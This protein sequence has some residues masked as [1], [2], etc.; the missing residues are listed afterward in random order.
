[1]QRGPLHLFWSVRETEWRQIKLQ[2]D[3]ARV[4]ETVPKMKLA[5]AARE[6]LTCR[7]HIFRDGNVLRRVQLTTPMAVVM[8]QSFFRTKAAS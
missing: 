7:L 3:G 2:M 8:P 6:P 4:G 1:M 5:P